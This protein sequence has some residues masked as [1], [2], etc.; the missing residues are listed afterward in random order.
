MPGISYQDRFRRLGR[1]YLLQTSINDLNGNIVCS[2]FYAGKLISTQVLPPFGEVAGQDLVETVHEIHRQYLADFESLLALVERTINSD[3][4]ELIEKIG[5]TL[6]YRKLFDEGLE[7]LE[8]AVKRFPEYP[9]YRSLFG[10]IYLALDRFSDAERELLRAVHLAPEYPDYRNMLG[11]AFLK[12]NKAVAAISEFNKAVET[13]VYYHRAYFNLGLAHILNGIVREDYQMAKNLQQNCDEAFG[14]AILFNP[15]YMN[16]DYQRG[17]VRLAE[18][19]L[20]DA[21]EDLLKAARSRETTT[22]HNELLELYLRN[23]HGQ[24]GMTENG[25]NDYIERLKSIIKINP[26]YADLHNEIGMAYTIMGKL[27]TDRA[28]A[29]FREAMRLNPDFS[30]AEKNLKLSENDLKGF[31]ILLG[32]ILK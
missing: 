3:K 4:P 27:I 13:N 19:K 6:Y 18:G 7:L 14:K 1:E 11:I 10:K 25:I 20:S 15:A 23:V 16:Q 26:G 31:E 21:Y 8:E 32:A 24:N 2:L 5:K 22:F 30:K 28:I 29:H 17:R 9:G 12:S